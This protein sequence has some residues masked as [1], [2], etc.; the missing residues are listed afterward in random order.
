MYK[1]R[2]KIFL[3][4]VAVI[5]LVVIGRLAQLQIFQGEHFRAEVDEY[6][7]GQPVFVSAGR[8]RITDRNGK[9]LAMDNPCFDLYLDYRFITN[10]TTWVETRRRR[11]EERE[12]VTPAQARRIYHSRADNT[13]RLA[14]EAASSAG[15]D[16]RATVDRIIRRVT[17]IRRGHGGPVTEEYQAHRVVRGLEK[18]VE[19]PDTVGAS[20]QT[21]HKRWYPYGRAACHVIGVI[22]PVDTAEQQRLNLKPDQADWAKRVRNNYFASDVI[23]KSGVEKMCESIL[24]GRRGYALRKR[25]GQLVERTAAEFGHDVHLTLDIDLQEKLSGLLKSGGLTGCIVVLAV[26]RGEVLAMVSVPD[27]DANLYRKNYRR[28]VGDKVYRPLTHRAVAGLYPPGSSVKPIA[29]LAAL[30]EGVITP[31]TTFNCKGYLYSPSAFRCWIWKYRRGH[32]LLDLRGGLKNSCNVYFYHIANKLGIGP[33]ASWFSMFGFTDVPGTG[34][35]EER[36]G[37]V[38]STGSIGIARHMA[39]GQG[40]ISVTPLHVA[41]A[42]A[43]IA[44]GA[45]LFSP[46]LVLETGPKRLRR[47]LP[48]SAA[49]TEA[50]KEG[51]YKVVNERGGTAYKRFHGPDV[52]PLD[53]EICG[54]TG[55]AEVPPLRA[56]S[57]GDGR[58][59][60]RDRI[61]R[62]GD[63]AWF[64]G[65]APYRK[66]RIAF[67]VVVE[68]VSG[69]GSEIAAPIARETV[70]ICRNLGYL[71]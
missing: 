37:K 19:L 9:I 23:G 53:V 2:I 69:G 46:V 50:V 55:T 30:G 35:P 7:Q 33:L 26:E 24:R 36:R 44:R 45:E 22:G 52:V 1:R 15:Q 38:A 16:L 60:N 27:Y 8:G 42:T 56:D 58:I 29:A 4:I 65:F 61:V 20:V 39:I 41:N 25:S 62:E 70:R 14:R 28:L 47:R 21:G 3:A 6:L 43:A 63:M 11:I 13:W 5:F 32:G 64:A 67:A 18:K 12:G 31:K 10:D 40:P 59:D 48:V 66:P 49:Y 51:M 57:N 68:Y 17:A 54:K 71:K 34:L